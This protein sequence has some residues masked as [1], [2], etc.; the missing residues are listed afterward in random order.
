MTTGCLVRVATFH[1][2]P[3]ARLWEQT[4]REEDIPCVARVLGA[5]PGALGQVSSMSY[6]L[7]VDAGD[8]ERARY[9]LGSSADV[10]QE[11]PTAPSWSLW[12]WPPLA[13]AIALSLYQSI[14]G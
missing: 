13:R 7:Y 8:E 9:L 1:G 4:L 5:G 12:S 6:A 11:E 2:E 14:A 3:L 10:P